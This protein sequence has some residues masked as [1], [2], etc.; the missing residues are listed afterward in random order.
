[1]TIYEKISEM[2]PQER[3][4]ELYL[5]QDIARELSF[6]TLDEMAEAE[7]LCPLHLPFSL[8]C[9]AKACKGKSKSICLKCRKEF[10]GSKLPVFK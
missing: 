9:N 1:M 7:V 4:R 6:L 5:P 3:S 2:W 8:N 10:L